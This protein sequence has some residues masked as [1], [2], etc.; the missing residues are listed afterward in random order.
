MLRYSVFILLVAS[1]LIDL[2]KFIALVGNNHIMKFLKISFISLSIIGIL[3]YSNRYFP[4]YTIHN[5]LLLNNSPYIKTNFIF[6]FFAFLFATLGFREVFSSDLSNPLYL[7]NSK[8]M[9]E[10]ILISNGIELS[11]FEMGFSIVLG[12]ILLFIS[13]ICIFKLFYNRHQ[14]LIPFFISFSLLKI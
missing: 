6:V 4:Q 12:L 10:I 14:L 8:K 5:P 7:L 13:L 11:K 3:Y 2:Y 1:V 9:S